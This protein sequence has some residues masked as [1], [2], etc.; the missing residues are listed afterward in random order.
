VVGVGSAG[1]C[2]RNRPLIERS[3]C[4]SGS[5]YKRSSPP[6]HANLQLHCL[7]L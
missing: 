5:Q 3:C 2:N 7:R 1:G 4:C 6:F